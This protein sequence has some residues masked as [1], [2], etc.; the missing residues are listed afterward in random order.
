MLSIQRQCIE[1]INRTKNIE[2]FKH[3]KKTEA[4]KYNSYAG[5][6]FM[7]E[8]IAK[9]G[10]EFKEYE[11]LE[12]GS[13]AGEYTSMQ[14][15]IPKLYGI[16]K[17]SNFVGKFQEITDNSMFPFF[18]NYYEIHTH[19]LEDKQEEKQ[20]NQEEK[21]SDSTK[22]IRASIRRD[23]SK[24]L[25]SNIAEKM[26][27]ACTEFAE[28]EGYGSDVSEAIDDYGLDD[29]KEGKLY[30]SKFFKEKFHTTTQSTVH[31]VTVES[32]NNYYG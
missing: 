3:L 14:K 25:N 11:G 16:S 28:D 1:I 5:V 31:D 30:T 12:D 19:F 15:I 20:S 21:Q 22:S 4:Y 8:L 13:F 6:L 10:K 23:L 17:S 32:I 9:R 7:I 24:T 26:I 29:L 27:T 2:F 18:Y